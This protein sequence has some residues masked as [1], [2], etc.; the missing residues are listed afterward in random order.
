MDGETNTMRYVS[1]IAFLLTIPAANWMVGNIG[2]CHADGPCVIPV[3][4]GVMA[5]SGVLL[6]GVALVLRDAVHSSLGWK[7][8][9]IAIIAGAALSFFVSP[10]SLA[11]A[12]GAAFLLSESADFAVYAP[13]YKRRLIAAVVASGIVGAIIDSCVFLFIAFGSLQFVE[14]N[15]IGKILMSV[16]ATAFISAKRRIA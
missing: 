1:F 9:A 2:H 12:S 11:V 8:A 3:W 7:W 6:I 4:P 16:L 10:T 5:P 13:L 14:G 15:V